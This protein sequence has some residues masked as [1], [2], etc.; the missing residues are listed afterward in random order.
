MENFSIYLDTY[1][2]EKKLVPYDSRIV[3]TEV[4]E[5][6]N[7]KMVKYL[8]PMLN[9]YKYCISETEVYIN[10]QNSHQYLNYNSGFL[11]KLSMNPKL[12]EGKPQYSVDCILDKILMSISL[13]Q[14]KAVMKLLAYQDLNSK[15]Q[16]GLAKEY[17]NKVLT[18]NEKISYTDD[19]PNISKQNMVQRKMKKKRNNMKLK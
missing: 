9:Y 4:T 3:N 6:K 17:Y 14:I 10:E 5:V 15:Y 12:K 16:I 13:V 2:N 18:E 11:I 8:G 19:S 7:E 1:E